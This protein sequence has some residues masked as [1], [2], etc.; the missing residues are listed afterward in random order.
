MNELGG[1]LKKQRLIKG[2]SEVELAS[3][4]GLSN[5]TICRLE[6]GKSKPSM[7]TLRKIAKALEI[8]FSEFMKEVIKN[9]YL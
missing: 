7:S 8:E 3:A 6:K 4:T 9:E 1:Y 5:V 2:F